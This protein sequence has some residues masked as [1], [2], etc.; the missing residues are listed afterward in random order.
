[1][2]T[3]SQLYR[4]TVVLI[5]EAFHPRWPF[6]E[7]IRQ[8]HAIGVRSFLLIGVTSFIV[9]MVFT[10]QSRPSLAQFGATAMI[11][12]MV[13]IAIVRALAPLVTALIASGKIGSQIG[14]ELGS[15]RV[16][17]QIDAMEVSGANPVKFLILTRVL[18]T[19]FMI[20]ILC[21]YSAAISLFGGFLSITDQDQ[22]SFLSYF[23]QVFGILKFV[24]LGAM[25]LRALVFGISIGLTSCYVG[26]HA[27]NGTQ[28]VGKA[29]NTAV[30]ASMFLVFIE[31][32]L[33]VQLFS[34]MN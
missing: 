33:L 14:A 22:L 32:L 31:E 10:V 12:A 23:T 1:M 9:G 2:I 11:P 7:I 19:T 8:C 6:K 26:Y 18:A 17:E 13:S 3:L 24:D 21:F 15:M 25:V 27:E 5:R 29:A 30:V 34:L 20:P 28:G 16:T 4:F